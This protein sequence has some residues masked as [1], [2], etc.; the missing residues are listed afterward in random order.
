[1][2]GY[3][4]DGFPTMVDPSGCACDDCL[5]GTSIPL[6]RASAAR[7]NGLLAGDLVNATGLDF[8][9]IEAVLDSL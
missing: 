9:D 1:M 8:S 2:A 7:L 3:T 4:N 5:I 6:H